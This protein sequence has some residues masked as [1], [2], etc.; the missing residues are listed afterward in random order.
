[1]LG[2][3]PSAGTGGGL[4]GGCERADPHQQQ[5][6]QQPPDDARPRAISEKRQVGRPQAP[7]GLA[8]AALPVAGL[9]LRS[10]NRAMIAKP[11]IA[12]GR[13]EQHDVGDQRQ[14]AA[15]WPAARSAASLAAREVA[16][17]RQAARINSA[18]TAIARRVDLSIT[19]HRY[20][21]AILARSCSAGSSDSA[22]TLV[23]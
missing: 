18:I 2:P 16:A 10:R 22:T 12:T 1:M 3:A 14:R 6:E 19:G 23:R 21:G 8:A 13:G 7:P 11:M 17:Q 4:I 9:A 5:D 15:R 20:Y